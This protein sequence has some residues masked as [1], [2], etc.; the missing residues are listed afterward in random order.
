METTTLSSLLWG[1]YSYNRLKFAE[2]PCQAVRGLLQGSFVGSDET[3]CDVKVGTTVGDRDA[4]VNSNAVGEGA[5][6]S[7]GRGV[8]TGV[9]VGGTVVLVGIA[10]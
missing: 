6:V 7:L 9:S 1:E 8:G 2:G 5:G 4:F 3:G 10:A